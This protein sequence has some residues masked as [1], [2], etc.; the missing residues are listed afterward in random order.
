M[1]FC[2][3]WLAVIHNPMTCSVQMVFEVVTSERNTYLIH[4][5]SLSRYVPSFVPPSFGREP[6]KKVCHWRYSHDC[7]C[8]QYGSLVDYFLDLQKEDERPK[9]KEKGKQRAIDTVMEE[10]KLEKE[11]RE[12]R[13]QERSSR[14]GDTSV[15][16]F[17]LV[18]L[19]VDHLV[20]SIRCSM[21]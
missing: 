6:E 14:H 8:S 21:K 1:S 7:L 18:Y 16:G 5:I 17:V 20:L 2:C 12:R 13:N 4:S 9:E 3:C 11:L 10:L 15:V 19:G